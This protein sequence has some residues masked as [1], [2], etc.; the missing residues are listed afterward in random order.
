MTDPTGDA[1][2]LQVF[3]FA[4]VVFSFIVSAWRE[5]RNR[6]WAA[7]DRTSATAQI[8]LDNETVRLKIAN[9]FHAELV[10]ATTKGAELAARS[11]A[12]VRE[13]S[14]KSADS[15]ELKL[16][17]VHAVAATA[18]ANGEAMNG[19]M[20]SLN[21]RLIAAVAVEKNRGIRLDVLEASAVQLQRE[22]EASTARLEAIRQSIERLESTPGGALARGP[23]P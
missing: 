19:L 15:I 12:V 8:M 10:T 3:T 7:E 16:D 18:L 14:R 20:E 23:T 1:T 5:K 11:A 21:R 17:Q 13:D 4:G 9:D 2:I 22:I 6:Q